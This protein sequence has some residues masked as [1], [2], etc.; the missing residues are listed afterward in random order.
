MGCTQPV[1]A[2][3]CHRLV[4]A[5]G[6]VSKGAR[7]IS[8]VTIT[9]RAGCCWASLTHCAGICTAKRSFLL[10][11]LC[12][13]PGQSNPGSSTT[14]DTIPIAGSSQTLLQNELWAGMLQPS[15]R[16]MTSRR[17][18]FFSAWEIIPKMD[19]KSRAEVQGCA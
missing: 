16:N 12:P 9:A 7:D 5:Q 18:F 4:L 6:I 15:G 13:L 8:G 10:S 14:Q 17:R 19:P 3:H 11:P 1:P 2:D